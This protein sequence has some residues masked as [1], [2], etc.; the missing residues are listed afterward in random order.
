MPSVGAAF[1]P[2]PPFFSRPHSNGTIY[3]LSVPPL[4]SDALRLTGVLR[5]SVRA[6]AEQNDLHPFSKIEIKSLV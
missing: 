2:S 4:N 3:F 5:W 1:G 6:T